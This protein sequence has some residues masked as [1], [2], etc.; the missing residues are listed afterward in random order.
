[1]QLDPTQIHVDL[2][3]RPVLEEESFQVLVHEALQKTPWLALSLFIHVLAVALVILLMPAPRLEEPALRLAV[4]PPEEAVEIER[5]IPDPPEQE[6]V[7]PEPAD[8]EPTDVDVD[9]PVDDPMDDVSEDSETAF[10][11]EFWNPAVGL[12]SGAG[13]LGK[14]GWGI[15]GGRRKGGPNLPTIRRGLEWLARHQDKTG[16]WDCDG[17]MKHDSQGVPCDGP[18]NAVHDVGITGLA[19]LAFLGDSSTMRSGPYQDNVKRGVMWLVKQQQPNGLFGTN[20]SNDFIYDHSI[21]ALAMCEAYGLSRYRTLKKYAQRGINY[22][23]SHRNPYGVW[24]YQPRSNDNDTSVTGWAF[25]VYKS[26]K[27][28]GLQVNDRTFDVTAQYFEQVTDPANGR[29]G[30]TRRG[31]LSS[32]HPG[33]HATRFPPEKGETLAA[34]GLMIRF[35]LGQDPDKVEVMKTAAD[36]ILKKPPVWKLDGS[37]DHYYWYYATYALYQMGGKHWRQWSKH[38]TGAVVKTQRT[39]GNFK[40]SWDPSGAWG[41]DGGRVYSTAALVLTLQAYYRYARVLVR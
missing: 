19:L 17:F 36:T 27:D 5:E 18:G 4:Q 40:G 21:A 16:K 24:R 31:E 6:P 37:I 2:Y 29:C 9:T 28:F 3:Q 26:A 20:M 7:E 33:T 34:V 13:S 15:R 14:K 22:L 11:S 32:R 8:L 1:M 39:D 23:E 12:G 25:M 41:E 30:Y 38:L 10:D 35:F